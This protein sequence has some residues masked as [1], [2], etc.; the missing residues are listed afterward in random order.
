MLD[1]AGNVIGAYY[2]GFKVDMKVV[3]DS[4]QSIH[5][6]ENSFAA[7]IDADNE[8]RFLSDHINL[9]EA[10]NIIKSQPENWVFV[11]DSTPNADY[12]WVVYEGNRM[13]LFCLDQG[14]GGWRIESGRVGCRRYN[15]PFEEGFEGY[16]SLE[17]AMQVVAVLV[18][19]RG[20]EFLKAIGA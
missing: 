13:S 14:P 10:D 4:V 17:E 19:T 8:I 16:S 15:Y 11:R 12:W 9:T 1:K 5:P 3:R 7:I 2:V 6:L 18:Y 20:H